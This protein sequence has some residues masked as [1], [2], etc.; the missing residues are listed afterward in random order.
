[1]DTFKTQSLSLSAALQVVSTSPLDCIEISPDDN[2]AT[3]VF[4]RSKDPSFD[5]I[6]ARFWAK[7]LPV[8]A[9][10]YFESLRYIKSRLYE[11]KN[12]QR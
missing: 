4:D 6:V 7:Q 5:E 9:Q 3:F 11:V 10:T 12:D 1:M 8:D 2:R